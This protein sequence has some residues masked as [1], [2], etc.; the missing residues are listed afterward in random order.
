VDLSPAAY[1]ELQGQLAT[2]DVVAPR[3]AVLFETMDR[4]LHDEPIGHEL[5]DGRAA[6]APF[7][8]WLDRDRG[9]SPTLLDHDDVAEEL[10]DTV[11]AIQAFHGFDDAL[12][13]IYRTLAQWP[14]FLT[15][16]WDDLEGRLASGAFETA[17]GRTETLVD[18]FVDGAPYSPQLAPAA[19]DRVG[20]DAETIDGVQTLFRTFNTGPVETVIPALPVYAATV[21]AAGVREGL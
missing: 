11:T 15:R 4:A 18:E 8:E 2:Y 1:R 7:P 3:L 10:A 5:E 12:P 14:S 19:L 6:T 16:L 21:D 20:F 9:R 17:C 13:S